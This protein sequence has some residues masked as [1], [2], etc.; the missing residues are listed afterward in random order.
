MLS[1]LFVLQADPQRRAAARRAP[2][3][4][5]PHQLD[6]PTE[7]IWART[8]LFA[9]ALCWNSLGLTLNSSSSAAEQSCCSAFS[10][11]S[12]CHPSVKSCDFVTEL[13]LRFDC[14]VFKDENQR[15]HTQ[16]ESFLSFFSNLRAEFS[17][18]KKKERK[19]L[20]SMMLLAAYSCICVQSV[21]GTLS[22]VRA[23]RSLEKESL[24][25]S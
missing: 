10:P 15:K 8:G 17:A 18:G 13:K 1:S 11:L 21:S 23:S 22:R 3:S 5:L 24:L 4:R 12:R 19:K 6:S 20:F 25:E 9:V 14:F 16:N 2:F 7:S